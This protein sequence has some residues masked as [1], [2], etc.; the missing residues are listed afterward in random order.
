MTVAT[1]CDYLRPFINHVVFYGG[2]H[3]C[4]FR[5]IILTHIFYGLIS[6]TTLSLKY[7][8]KQEILPWKPPEML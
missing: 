2:R 7:Q 3:L 5:I 8:L 6:K 4:R 1:F